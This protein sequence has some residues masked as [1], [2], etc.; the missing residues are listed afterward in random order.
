MIVVFLCRKHN[1]F[2]ELKWCY[3]KSAWK[4]MGSQY[5]CCSMRC[6]PSSLGGSPALSFLNQHCYSNSARSSTRD[7]RIL[8][9]SRFPRAAPLALPGSVRVL[10]PRQVVLAALELA[11]A[12]VAGDARLLEAAC[13]LGL[14]PAVT[15]YAFA[16]WPLPLRAQAAAFVH[17]LCHASSATACMFVACQV[18]WP[19]RDVHVRCLFRVSQP[20]I[21]LL[22]LARLVGPASSCLC[23][24][25]Y[26]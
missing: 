17:A 25:M 22:E 12:L 10:R 20:W 19:P 14:P 18:G 21:G 24:S 7:V 5:L 3:V 23:P 2:R 4:A 8:R 6:G 11:N 1:I 13:L 15:R 9:V 26:H 16:A